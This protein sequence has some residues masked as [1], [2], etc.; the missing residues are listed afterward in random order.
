MN[1]FDGVEKAQPPKK[2]KEGHHAIGIHYDYE[3]TDI[4]NTDDEE[5]MKNIPSE[6]FYPFSFCPYCGKSVSER[7]ATEMM[8]NKRRRRGGVRN[9]TRC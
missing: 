6:Y 5:M 1:D 2:C 8:R 3:D 9:V 4:V 7:M